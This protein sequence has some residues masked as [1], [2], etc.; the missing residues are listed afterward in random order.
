MST[1]IRV[2]KGKVQSSVCNFNFHRALER[3]A[4][5]APT[6]VP[7]RKMIEEL[8]FASANQSY[9]ADPEFLEEVVRRSAAT[10]E[11]ILECG[12]GLATILLGLFAGAREVPVWTLTQACNLR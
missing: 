2:L 7:D 4:R 12:S 3:I 8:F 5:G 11:P 1:T 9:G 10:T 6:Q